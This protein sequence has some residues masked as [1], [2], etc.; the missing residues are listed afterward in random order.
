MGLSP[1][2]LLLV[3]GAAINLWLAVVGW[4][5]RAVTAAV[6][7]VAFTLGS[8][9]W[10]ALDAVQ[11]TVTDI[12]TVSLL[13]RLSY[14]GNVVVPMAAFVFVL[15]YTGREHWLTPPV[16]AFVVGW[17][18]LTFLLAVTS[19]LHGL[20]WADRA[21][22]S[23]DPVT[24]TD[25]VFG[26][27]FW[28]DMV[29]IYSMLLVSL[30]L[31]GKTLLD[32]YGTRRRQTL[33]VLAAALLPVAANVP[34]LLDASPIPGLDLTPFG[35]AGTGILLGV[36]LFAFGFLD[37]SPVA[38]DAIVE[39]MQD[40]VLAVDRQGHIADLNPAAVTLLAPDR[41]ASDLLGTP[42]AETVP[43]YDN[44]V[45]DPG[46]RP[47][48]GGK[49]TD[50]TLTTD[51]G[52]R[53]FDAR[54]SPLTD[55]AGEYVGHLIILRDVTEQRENER[56]L[57]ESERQNRTLVDNIPNGLI[58]L[59]D[60]D[61]RY[62]RVGGGAMANLEMS[63]D[64]FEGA[65]LQEAHTEDFCDRHRSDY[66]AVFEGETAEF[67]FSAAGYRWRTT[68]VP[69]EDA[70]DSVVSI[71][72][73][74]VDV[75]QLRER[76]RQLQRQN[77]RLEEFVGV[78]SHDLRN[79]L[80]VIQ[81][82]LDLAAELEDATEHVEHAADAADRMEQLIEDLLE[83]ARTGSDVEDAEPLSLEAVANLAWETIN[84]PEATLTVD[85]DATVQADESRLRQALE[86]LFRNAV[87]H[88]GPDVDIRV[89]D[90]PNGFAVVDDGPGFPP[91]VDVLERGVT[92]D[93]DGTGF[94]LSIVTQVAGPTGGR[95]P[96]PTTR[97]RVPEWNS[98]ASEPLGDAGPQSLYSRRTSDTADDRL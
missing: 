72:A 97:R 47:A 29:V 63:A 83:L 41:S 42:A 82:R 52:I 23:T 48:D 30:G 79:P 67:E 11:Y 50:V 37:L 51:D 6:P 68:L 20:M 16:K 94:G 10:S 40:P 85:T 60:E 36:A 64:D 77:E 12:G 15:L 13:A 1:L 38:R 78:V 49:R 81:G 9:Y 71:L 56:K 27:W 91:D 74:T 2:V 14:L 33:L 3:V 35:F 46:T 96:P 61:L 18:I 66:E 75:T 44:L 53:Y 25:S 69:V 88:A 31:L 7:F 92:T 59:L 80:N 19:P 43:G 4:Q 17:P 98:P 73:F 8:A 70:T 45:E 95:S 55:S 76:E 90:A 5:R 28:I 86:N 39:E 58:A 21:V 87:E 22:V 57:A 26:P 84:A 65:T 34:W 32:T 89:V 24:L 54:S 62:V 93:D